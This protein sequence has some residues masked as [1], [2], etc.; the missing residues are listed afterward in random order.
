M[1]GA[2]DSTDKLFGAR[3]ATA[4]VLGAC[5][6][7]QPPAKVLALLFRWVLVLLSACRLIDGW[8]LVELLSVWSSNGPP[9]ARWTHVGGF[10]A[11]ASVI[12]PFSDKQVSLFASGLRR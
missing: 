4:V 8:P 3:G 12:V 5:L 11:G 6:V 2:R 7:L 1:L 9:V 10:V